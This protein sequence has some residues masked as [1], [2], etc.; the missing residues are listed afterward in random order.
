MITPVPSKT[1]IKN[2][3]KTNT[4]YNDLDTLANRQYEQ[5]QTESSGWTYVF[6]GMYVYIVIIA[7][8]SKTGE[9]I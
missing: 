5:H 2:V 3:D 4:Q 6:I 7:K 9:N 8:E 1:T